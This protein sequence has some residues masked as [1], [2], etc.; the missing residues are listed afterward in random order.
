MEKIMEEKELPA[1]EEEKELPGKAAPAP[2]P[3][4]PVIHIPEK[5]KNSP[6]LQP[7][8]APEPKPAAKPAGKEEAFTPGLNNPKLILNAQLNRAAQNAAAKAAPHPAPK[9]VPAPPAAKPPEEHAIR[10]ASLDQ[11]AKLTPKDWKRESAPAFVQSLRGL[12]K[13]FGYHDVMFSLEKSPLYKAYVDTGLT[14]L[15]NQTDFAELAKQAPGFRDMYL[16]REDFESLADVLR[17]LP[18]G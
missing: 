12:I 9:P 17:Q 1:G 2:A 11:I 14:I 3:A 5:P 7:A 8:P 16:M 4:E 6:P 18:V 13:Q 15:K 10:L